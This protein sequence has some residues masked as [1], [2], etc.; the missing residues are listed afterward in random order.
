MSF[1]FFFLFLGKRLSGSFWLY[2]QIFCHSNC[3]IGTRTNENPKDPRLESFPF[4]LFKF[5][6]DLFR[7]LHFYGGK[8]YLFELPKSAI[9]IT[10]SKLVSSLQYF[11]TVIVSLSGRIS[12]WIIRLQSHQ[13]WQPRV[14]HIHKLVSRFVCYHI[15]KQSIFH[16][17]QQFC[18]RTV[19][20]HNSKDI[21]AEIQW[22]LFGSIR[23][24]GTHMLSL[25]NKPKSP[26]LSSQ[27]IIQ[28]VSINVRRMLR[29]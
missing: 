13:N 19:P 18:P 4:Q 25:E 6:Q 21:V 15:H 16:H 14:L 8:W 5:L 1:F 27:R 7:N 12:K 22:S 10:T 9:W 24:C 3:S 17:L 26:C 23:K 20:F 11:S 28:S 2:S 29:T